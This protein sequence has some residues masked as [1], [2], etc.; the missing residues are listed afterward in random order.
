MCNHLRE[1][2]FVYKRRKK[3]LDSQNSHTSYLSFFYTGKIFVEKNLHRKTPIFR[4][5]SEKIYTGQ[6]NLH[7]YI[8]G[9]RDKYEVWHEVSCKQA[10]KLV[11]VDALE[12]LCN[13]L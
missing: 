3:N 9:A 11:Q 8:R 2:L 10:Q 4:V 6:K 5:K 12:T 7:E 13:T 1:I